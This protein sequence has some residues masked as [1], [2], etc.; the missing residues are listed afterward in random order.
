MDVPRSRGRRLPRTAAL[1]LAAV[2]ALLAVPATAVSPDFSLSASR[3]QLTVSFNGTASTAVTVTPSDGFAGVVTFSAAGLPSGVR[4]TFNPTSSATGTALTF[5]SR[6]PSVT[7]TYP[8]TVT[9]V[10]GGLSHALVISLLVVA[11]VSDFA[12]W[13]SP[14]SLT[15]NRGG[16]ATSAIATTPLTGFTGSVT[17]GTIAL[18]N[19]V[20]ASFSPA[21]TPAGGRTTLTVT[22]SSGTGAGTSRIIVSGSG[23]GRVLGTTSITLTVT[24]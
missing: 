17:Y 20:T 6:N 9:G 4:A 13:A 24:G 5:S 10:S 14:A 23:G 15:A 11:P 1:L 19:G 8:I 2:A 7:A 18:P 12:I 16:T 21:S 22:V 3:S